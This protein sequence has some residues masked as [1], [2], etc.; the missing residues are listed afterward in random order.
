MPELLV[1]GNYE[2]YKKKGPAIWLKCMVAKV[3][4]EADWNKEFTPIIYLPDISKNDLK[5]L[6]NADPQIAPL[7]EYQYTVGN[8]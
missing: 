4:P 2:P 5:N 7:M 1:F 6:S 3:L 8:N